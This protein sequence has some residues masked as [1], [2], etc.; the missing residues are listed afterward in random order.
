[1][2]SFFHFSHHQTNQA[3][4]DRESESERVWGSGPALESR[5]VKGSWLFVSFRLQC[6]EERTVRATAPSS[7]YNPFRG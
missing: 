7:K 5:A 1:M 6:P 3:M 4:D 2:T